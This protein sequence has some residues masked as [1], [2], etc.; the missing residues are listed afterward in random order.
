MGVGDWA[1]GNGASSG[2][3]SER[4]APSSPPCKEHSEAS[5]E[6][7][8]GGKKAETPPNQPLTLASCSCLGCFFF[9]EACSSALFPFPST[10]S[11][12]GLKKKKKNVADGVIVPTAEHERRRAHIHTQ[13]DT[14]ACVLYEAQTENQKRE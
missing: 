4:P 12:L 14:Y 7:T 5:D 10:A 11:L 2:R 8:K 9:V 3:P 1:G 13:R 6:G